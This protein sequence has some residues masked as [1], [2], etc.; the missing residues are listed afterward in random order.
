MKVVIFGAGEQ[1]ETYTMP[2]IS[3]PTLK[4]DAGTSVT[5]RSFT[6]LAAA[7]AAAAQYPGDIV[8]YKPAGA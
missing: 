3:L 6:D 1:V 4:G 5:V 7:Q 8:T 2:L